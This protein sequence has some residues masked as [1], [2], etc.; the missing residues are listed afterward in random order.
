MKIIFQEGQSDCGL[1]CMAMIANHLGI[2]IDIRQLK[3]SFH[4]GNNPL[5]AADIFTVSHDLGIVCRALRVEME[6]ISSL[7]LP[8][9][10]HW[11]MNHFVVLEKV[12]SKKL[13]IID[14]SR[15]RQTISITNAS[16]KF[17]GIA[18]EFQPK[19]KFTKVSESAKIGMLDFFKSTIRFRSALASILIVSVSLEVIAL[20]IPLISQW[21]IDGAIASHD[22]DFLLLAI[23]GGLFIAAVQFLLSIYSDMQ[24]LRISQAIGLQW[25]L[26]LFSHLLKLP[27]PYF[28]SRHAGQI[29]S[30]FASLK[31]IKE[32]IISL[33]TATTV[34]IIGI[35]ICII[36]MLLYSPT[37]TL[38]VI[39]GCI[40]YSLV[41]V[42]SYPILRDAS[43][44]RIV[45]SAKEHSQFL[46]SV[47][48]VLT[49]KLTRQ[50]ATRVSL[51]AN[52]VIDLQN[53]DSRTQKIEI[54]L[55]GA[56]TLIFALESMSVL[57]V[58]ALAVM[59]NSLTMGMLIAF[60]AF[61]IY[62]TTRV[63]RI[64]DMLIQYK[65][66]RIHFARIEDIALTHPEK[67][68]GGT[69]ALGDE[70]LDI[71]FKNVS[72]RYAESQP[73]ILKNISIKISA[74]ESV[75]VTGKSGSGKSTFAHL[76]VGLV[77]PTRGTILIGGIPSTE[78]SESEL[79]KKIGTILQEDQVL[80]GTIA[81]NISSFTPD[82]Q[83]SRIHQVA[84][85][86]NIHHIICKLSSGY[87]TLISQENLLLS[88]GQ[89]QRLKLAR[90][91]YGDPN[92]LILDE[93]T[94]NLD[95]HSEAHVIQ[96]L[97]QQG[98]TMVA[99]AHRRETLAL[100]SRLIKL[101][102]GAITKDIAI[103]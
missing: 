35:C 70:P 57:Y 22:K 40:C 55:A 98:S 6:E 94:S 10:L 17:T 72:F 73:W 101:E 19:H 36:L 12:T 14:P 38:I 18:L 99:V 32:F 1:A 50:I 82:M 63:S 11:S 45:L 86:A 39:A 78:I 4:P 69:V 74:G 21:I 29:S 33:I 65:M 95:L 102:E 91:L 76:I 47:S 88:A 58:G 64:I 75:I 93:A 100:G 77:R 49:I 34:D 62:F 46:E 30:R 71:E 15:G 89:I 20:I 42:V 81:E 92:V 23:L 56:N 37:L 52:Q 80:T 85:Q 2:G 31:P 5:S 7:K 44:E 54:T 9:I 60:I 8:C 66:Q 79:R 26:Q 59:D 53:R 3:N 96:N 16:I 51:W 28:Q 83:I 41:K 87:Q 67:C 90:L 13:H 61:K 68:S 24:K 97:R 43:S 48:S 84:K 27:W 25:S 103:T